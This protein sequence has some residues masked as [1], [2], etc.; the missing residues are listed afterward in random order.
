MK[1][2]DLKIG[3]TV[4]FHGYGAVVTK[5]EVTMIC[6]DEVIVNADC[7]MLIPIADVIRIVEKP[8]E[9]LAEVGTAEWALQMM[10]LGHKVTFGEAVGDVYWALNTNGDVQYWDASDLQYL[11]T[12]QSQRQFLQRSNITSWEL[13]K[14]KPKPIPELIPKTPE[15]AAIEYIRLA[16]RSLTRVDNLS[17]HHVESL[18]KLC[19]AR[20]ALDSVEIERTKP[21]QD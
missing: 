14:P 20:E 1:V 21:D 19:E 18:L 2:Q 12:I 15:A 16:E 11:G 13:Y 5:G 8:S 17:R 9:P 6:Q 3:D 4:E 7:E 10:L